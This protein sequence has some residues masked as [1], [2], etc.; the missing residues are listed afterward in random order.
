MMLLLALACTDDMEFRVE[1]D[2]ATCEWKSDCYGEDFNT[3]VETA[4]D[5]FETT[6]CFFEEQEAR[7]CIRGLERME[8]PVE[9]AAPVF[10][11]V[12]ERVWTCPG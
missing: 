5:Q 7:Q 10:P 2:A 12:C 3:C 1:A 4:E 8:C 6:G 11:E 9:G